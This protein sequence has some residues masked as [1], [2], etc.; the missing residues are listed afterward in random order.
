MSQFVL[1]LKSSPRKKGNS[2]TLA[3]RVA[4]GAKEAGAT[5]ESL[6]LDDMSIHPCDACDQCQ[7]TGMCV[8]KDDM[9]SIYSLIKKADAILIASP[10]YWF[11]FS[12]QIKLC[13]DRWYALSPYEE[14]FRGKQSGIVLTYGDDDLHSSGGINAIHTLESM[15]RYLD[16]EITGIV[17]GSADEVGDVEKQPDLMEQAYQL[18][19]ALGA[20]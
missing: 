9:Q 4:A 19:Q 16:M 18:G 17:H 8:V 2:N 7:E 13:L 15:F 12:A 5:V 14:V 11:T 6:M 3:E 1:V 20:G 10:V